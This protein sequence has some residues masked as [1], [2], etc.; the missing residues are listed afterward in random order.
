MVVI[1]AAELVTR[2]GDHAAPLLQSLSAD[3]WVIMLNYS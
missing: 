3:N 1:D 2:P